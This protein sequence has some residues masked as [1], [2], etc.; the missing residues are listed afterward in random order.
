[1][2]E[3]VLLVIF[4]SFILV[5]LLFIG[6][7]SDK[8]KPIPVKFHIRGWMIGTLLVVG[9]WYTGIKLHQ[10]NYWFYFVMFFVHAFIAPD[11]YLIAEHTEHRPRNYLLFAAHS[12]LFVN[13]YWPYLTAVAVVLC[14]GA[15]WLRR[16]RKKNGD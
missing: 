6:L 3:I 4:S 10:K 13:E 1:M 2:T 8:F 7:W 9:V 14:V 12:R 15:W 16:R 11:D 5:S